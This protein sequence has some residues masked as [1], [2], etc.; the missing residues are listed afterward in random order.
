MEK[1]I[2]KKVNSHINDFKSNIQKWIHEKKGC[3]LIDGEDKT[4]EFIQYMVDFPNI[5][6]SKEDFQKRKRLKNNIPDF[7]RCIALKCNG[8]RCSRRQ[9]NDSVS[10]CGTHMKG[11]NY[12]TVNHME[13]QNKKEKVQLWLQEINGIC[14]YIDKDYNVYCMEDILNNIESPRIVG[15]YGIHDINGTYYMIT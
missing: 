2:H 1:N 4:N 10:F 8:E 3:I 7:N 15:K 9:K 13:Q 5:E 14:R 12:G 11:A 6:L